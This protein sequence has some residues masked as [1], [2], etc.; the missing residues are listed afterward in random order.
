[1]KVRVPKPEDLNALPALGP[2]HVLE[3]AAAIVQNALRAQHIQLEG[4]FFP[5]EPDD[6]TTARVLERE[7][8]MIRDTVHHFRRRV[9]ARLARERGEWPF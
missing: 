8:A 4:D 6:V 9:L 2:L 7:C 5:G 3:L 1:M